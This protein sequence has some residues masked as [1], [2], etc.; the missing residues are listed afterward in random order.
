MPRRFNKSSAKSA[1][2]NSANQGWVM[3]FRD[4]DMN[5]ITDIMALNP[6]MTFTEPRE[7]SMH[8]RS[9]GI[10][11]TFTWTAPNRTLICYGVLVPVGVAVPQG[12]IDFAI[13]SVI[14]QEIAENNVS[15]PSA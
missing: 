15:A 13:N 3:R 7:V 4:D 10:L 1:K 14:A 8:G 9:V 12:A 6:Q 11:H 5:A 2:A